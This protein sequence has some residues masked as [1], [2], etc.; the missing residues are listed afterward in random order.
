MKKIYFPIILLVLSL[1]KID[2]QTSWLTRSGN[3]GRIGWNNNE[4]TLTQANV[5]SGN[6]GKI[7]ELPTD[8]QVYAQPLIVGHYTIN[9]GRH[10]VAIIATVNNTIYAYN[11]DT[12]ATPFWKVNLTFHHNDDSAAYY[13]PVKN[14]DIPCGGDGIYVNFTTK[15]GIVGTP[16]IDTATNTIY[17]VAR[18]ASVD[19]QSFYYHLHA[20]DLKTGADKFGSPSLIQGSVPG[21]GDG[22]VNGVVSF[23]PL[24]ELQRPGLCLYNNTIYVCW[25]S[26]CDHDPYH[27]W[28]M[29]FDATS[30]Q[31]KYIYCTTPTGGRGG[32]WMSG[33][34]PA[35]DN[36]GYIYVSVGNGSV[37]SPG[38][39]NDTSNTGESVLKLSTATGN[40]HVVDYFTPYNWRYLNDQDLDYGVDGVMLFP[41]TQFSL[42]GS[43][44]SYLYL[45]NDMFM[46]GI[47]R[48]N[49]DVLESIDINA[50]NPG[51]DRHLHGLPVYFKDKNKNE[52]IYAWA[53]EGL[54][55]QIPFNRATKRFDTLNIKV[56]PTALGVGMPGGIPTISSNGN[57]ATTAVLWESHHISEGKDNSE[58]SQK[59]ILQ[60]FDASDVSHELWNSNWEG[61]RDSIGLYAKYVPPTVANGKVYMSSF[62][63]YI[64]VYGMNP[65]PASA[66]S[67]T[68][69]SP[70]HSADIG[71]DVYPGDVCENNGVFTITSSGADMY[72]NGDAF[73]YLYQPITSNAA[74]IT[75]RLDSISSTTSSY[76]K[77]GINIRANLDPG[78]PNVFMGFNGYRN[79]IFQSRILQ[80]DSTTSTT[81]NAYTFPVWIKV[82]MNGNEYVGYASEDSLNWTP[83]DS[84]TVALGT[85]PYA[86]IAYTAHTNLKTGNA[87]VDHLSITSGTDIGTLNFTAQNVDNTHTH[88]QWQAGKDLNAGNF[89]IE[90]S[91][92]ITN[93]LPVKTVTS[94]PSAEYSFDDYNPE[95]G[96]N[97]YRIR[98]TMPDGSFKYSSV[99]V[100]S[101]YHSIIDIY[102]N[103]TKGQLFIKVTKQLADNN[104]LDVTVINNTGQIVYK[105]TIVGTGYNEEAI[106]LPPSLVNGLY[107]VQVVNSKGQK[108]VKQVVLNR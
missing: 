61:Q 84:V 85:F 51:K 23:D 108:E 17:A 63:D 72:Q 16:V 35:V 60:A 40:L 59:G 101:F 30:L 24:R 55:K 104:E 22:S 83:V 64:V 90:R 93:F 71:F 107:V 44:A 18:S 20:I 95:E 76:A 91:T 58:Q 37:G 54:L 27:G 67:N 69:Q 48:D 103:P 68:L 47:R 41:N 9:G 81:G 78:S 8:D 5:S 49:K 50:E 10:N 28:V 70:W 3:L 46:G 77:C 53:E 26:Q 4:K 105:T 31:R 98:K 7:F 36:N 34:A 13:R 62:S 45:V 66:C 99:Q 11:A 79:T 75:V 106:N 80:N 94:D 82:T 21:T 86:G 88:L 2:A 43:K 74:P 32:I 12:L 57:D 19:G 52:Y 96:T 56:G 14:T 15:I 100:V 29:G 65:P 97:Y 38:N 102:P 89:T 73:H 42:S 25:S 6:F 39:Q 33:A 92:T 1:C 87:V